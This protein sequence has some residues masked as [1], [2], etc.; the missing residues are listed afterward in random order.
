MQN[1]KFFRG[2]VPVGL[3]VMFYPQAD[4]KARITHNS[5]PIPG[6][7]NF[8]DENGFCDLNVF[9]RYGRCLLK[10]AVYPAHHPDTYDFDT[11]AISGAGYHHGCWDFTPISRQQYD[12][13]IARQE[14]ALAAEDTEDTEAGETKEVKAAKANRRSTK[15]V[16]AVA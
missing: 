4:T 14:A 1:P 10:K 7:V 15:Q 12:D 16:A 3:V 13:F 5:G 9:D 6:I 8:C 2:K 11:N